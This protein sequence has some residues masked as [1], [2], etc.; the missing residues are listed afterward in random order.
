MFEPKSAIIASPISAFPES[1]LANSFPLY[2]RINDGPDLIADRFIAFR[3]P[4]QL[5][6]VRY[7]SLRPISTGSQLFFQLIKS[8]W[9]LALGGQVDFDLL[10]DDRLVL[11]SDDNLKFVLVRIIQDCFF[12]L[13][14]LF[15]PCSNFS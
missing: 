11:A 5:V 15:F 13:S 2:K 1:N 8:V 10:L 4:F 14:L 7:R 6:H 12:D 9:L 3:D